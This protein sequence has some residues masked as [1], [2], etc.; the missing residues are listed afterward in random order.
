[1]KI[2]TV[3]VDG[4]RFLRGWAPLRSAPNGPA[5]EV[6]LS[7]EILRDDPGLA[8]ALDLPDEAW[9]AFVGEARRLAAN[10]NEAAETS[11]SA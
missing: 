11:K 4:E 7:A 6:T 10:G 1:V 8:V 5:V 3:M 2:F 9:A